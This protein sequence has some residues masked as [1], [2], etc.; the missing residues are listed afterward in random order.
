MFTPLAFLASVAEALLVAALAGSACAQASPDWRGEEKL[1]GLATVY[2]FGDSPY[3]RVAPGVTLVER[4]RFSAGASVFRQSRVGLGQALD[5]SFNA[6]SC[7]ACHFRNGRGLAHVES[8]EGSG[9]SIASI[10]GR[11]DP[12]LFRHRG[13]GGQAV[14]ALGI[15]WRFQRRVELAGGEVVELVAPF[16]TIGGREVRADIRNAPGV[17]GLGLLEAVPGRA[18]RD[19]ARARRY[20]AFGVEG[21]VAVSKQDGGV[22]RFGWKGKFSSLESQVHSAIIGEIGVRGSAEGSA[23]FLKLRARLAD[24]MRMLAVPARRSVDAS[25][26]Q[27]GAVLFSDVGCT[28]CHAPTWRT[29]ENAELSV[30][31]GQVIHPFTDFLLHDMGEGLEGPPRQDSARLWQTPPLWGLGL[32]ESVSSGV[33]YLHDGRARSLLEAILWHEGEAGGA[34][35]SFRKLSARDRADLLL[36]LLSL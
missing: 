15:V 13:E 22:G 1:G 19:H 28:M 17:F 3:S 21:V 30:L 16:V 9:L 18:I 6:A 29:G 20:A 2:S 33:G 27:R 23:G 4:K 7:A 8:L 10:D 14:M 31:R 32:Q 35:R 24:Y 36:F 25:K 5:A 12:A 11:P 34:N 26:Y